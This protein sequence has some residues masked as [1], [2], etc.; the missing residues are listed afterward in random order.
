MKKLISFSSGFAFL[1]LGMAGFGEE[2]SSDFI[3]SINPD[4][5]DVLTEKR[6]L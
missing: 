2:T 1:C 5:A 4:Y 3:T 6:S